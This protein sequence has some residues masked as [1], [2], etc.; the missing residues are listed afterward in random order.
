M[1]G[2]NQIITYLQNNRI[3]AMKLDHA[4]TGIKQKVTDQLQTMGAG[5]NR[6]VNYLSCFTDEYYDVCQRQ[7]VEDIRFR[8]GVVKIVLGRDVAYDMLLIYFE[9]ILK[10]KTN[11]QL[12]Y[13]K[14]VLMGVNVHIAASSLTSAGFSMAVASCV[15]LG[16]SLSVELSALAGRG[17]STVA[18]AAGL[19]GIVQK[20]ADSAHR[21]HIQYPAFYAALYTHELE[22]MYFLIEPVFHHASAMEAQWANDAGIAN[23]INRMINP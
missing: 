17:V 15:R 3:L 21:L 12:E 20:S 6:A 10:H 14:K 13:I 9:E 22:M 18:A 7:Q 23:I 8:D 5:A 16:L 2:N 19:Y 11:D 1:Y 4:V